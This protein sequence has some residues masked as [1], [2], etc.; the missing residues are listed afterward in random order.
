MQ[1]LRSGALLLGISAAAF[2]AD[3]VFSVPVNIRSLP[4]FDQGSVDCVISTN[5][6]NYST[7]HLVGSGRQF[8]AIVAGAANRTVTVEVTVEPAFAYRIPMA[9][10]YSCILSIY[11]SVTRAGSDAQFIANQRPDTQLQP[12]SVFRPIVRGRIT[13]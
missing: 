10:A 8:F 7:Q 2:A 5:P 1:L 3:F 9:A 12:G 13:R 4:A 6:E 11:S